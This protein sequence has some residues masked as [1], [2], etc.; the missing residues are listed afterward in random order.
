[1]TLHVIIPY[2]H[3][4]SPVAAG[5]LRMNLGNPGWCNER[6]DRLNALDTAYTPMLRKCV[7]G[8]EFEQAKLAAAQH[9]NRI[10]R[11]GKRPD[12]WATD[13]P[14]RTTP[15]AF[16]QAAQ[17]WHTQFGP[18][19]MALPGVQWG[20]NTALTWM[21]QYLALPGAVIPA[22]WT[23]RI[24]KTQPSMDWRAL[25]EDFRQY[26]RAGGVERPL[27][28]EAT[29]VIPLTDLHGLSEKVFWYSSWNYDRGDA[30]F[31]ADAFNLSDQAG[32]HLTPLGTQ[33]KSV[34]AGGGG[35]TTG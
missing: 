24:Y 22:V 2:D 5:K 16:A 28:I 26:V 7:L 9:P 14:F 11:L 19:T 20:Q 1:M 33:F 23:L 27:W 4:S 8:A 32:N 17:N 18:G 34:V 3:L 31:W 30:M 25:I 21:N 13:D 35:G 10:W 15:Q 6:F 12:T 29:G